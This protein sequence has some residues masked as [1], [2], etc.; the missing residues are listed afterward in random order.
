MNVI[1]THSKCTC[2]SVRNSIAEFQSFAICLN[3]KERESYFYV[4]LIVIKSASLVSSNEAGHLLHH[5]H[6]EKMFIKY[7]LLYSLY[8]HWGCFKELCILLRGFV[9]M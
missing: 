8:V 5:K 4:Q 6:T 3:F 7:G 1:G 2:S 9:L